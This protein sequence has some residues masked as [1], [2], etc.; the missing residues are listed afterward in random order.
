MC[1][2]LNRNNFKTKNCQAS[3]NLSLIDDKNILSSKGKTKL[4]RGKVVLFMVEFFHFSYFQ[5]F[6][7]KIWSFFKTCLNVE[8][9]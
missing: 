1:F 6:S 9:N 3:F 8:A 7:K 4:F 2:S 5:H